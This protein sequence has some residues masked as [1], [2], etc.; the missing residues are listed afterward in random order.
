GLGTAATP[1]RDAHQAISAVLERGLHWPAAVPET[2]VDT[3]LRVAG[4]DHG[5]AVEVLAVVGRAGEVGDDRNGRDPEDAAAVA[6]RSRL[7]RRPPAGDPLLAVRIPEV[8]L[9]G[10][11]DVDRG[12][13]LVR[14]GQNEVGDVV[15]RHVA[16]SRPEAGLEAGPI[17]HAL[18][19]ERR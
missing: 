17:G 8:V 12:G 3:A 10:T 18:D 16:V 11:G 19:R 9:V 5:P 6:P 2:G 4:A 13:R 15:L 14:R 1:A 7:G